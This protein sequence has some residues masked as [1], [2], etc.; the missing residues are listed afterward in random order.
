MPKIE[1]PELALVIENAL[2][3]AQERGNNPVSII[4][5]AVLDLIE[6]KRGGTEA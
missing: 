1:E 2:V 3:H 6:E 5:R 4:A